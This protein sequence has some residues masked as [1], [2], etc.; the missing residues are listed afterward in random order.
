MGGLAEQYRRLR[1]RGAREG[2][3][4]AGLPGTS[5]CRPSPQPIPGRSC[6]PRLPRTRPSCPAES[7]AFLCAAQVLAA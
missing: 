4:R 7:L 6:S 2:E 3:E 5:S 1:G